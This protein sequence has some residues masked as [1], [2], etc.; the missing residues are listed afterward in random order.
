MCDSVSRVKLPPRYRMNNG[1]I[2]INAKDKEQA[3]IL[4]RNGRFIETGMK[5]LLEA[6][7]N[8]GD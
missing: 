6:Q 4:V 7:K 1:K 8:W 3:A 2:G 5:L